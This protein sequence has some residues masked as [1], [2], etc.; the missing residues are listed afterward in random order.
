MI[1]V[2]GSNQ[3]KDSLTE[4]LDL[5]DQFGMR[6]FPALP[7]ARRDSKAETRAEKRHLGTLKLILIS[8][9]L[10]ARKRVAFGQTPKQVAEG[11]EALVKTGLE[12]I[13][14]QDSRG[15]GKVGLF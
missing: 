2:A 7:L 10:D 11:F 1:L 6:V 13:A 14:P 12:I 4:L 5:A 9:Y 3:D 8:P 15:T